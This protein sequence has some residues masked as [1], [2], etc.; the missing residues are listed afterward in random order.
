MN[1]YRGMSVDK[2]VTQAAAG[3][4][5]LILAGGAI[6]GYATAKFEQT[7]QKTP[8]EYKSLVI[9]AYEVGGTTIAFSII[10]GAVYLWNRFKP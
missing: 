8:P 2:R 10:I 5:G 3:I 9:G 6:G 1:F 4:G 7:I